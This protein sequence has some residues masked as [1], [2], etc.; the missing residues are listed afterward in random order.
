MKLHWTAIFHIHLIFSISV[1]FLAARG[2]GQE[3]VPVDI[4]LL[5]ERLP[6][7]D[8]GSHPKGCALGTLGPVAQILAAGFDLL[9]RESINL[10]SRK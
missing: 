8:L 4:G 3:A 9:R 6:E 1:F 10:V 7:H 5:V 2:I